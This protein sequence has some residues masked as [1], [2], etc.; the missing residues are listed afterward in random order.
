MSPVEGGGKQSCTND[1]RTSWLTRTFCESATKDS[2]WSWLT[3]A[4]G[5]MGYEKTTLGIHLQPALDRVSRAR[6]AVGPG[7]AG[8]RING[9]R[10]IGV[11]VVRGHRNRQRPHL[12]N[13]VVAENRHQGPRAS[14]VL[15]RRVPHVHGEHA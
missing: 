6:Q 5:A 12:V 9:R 4:F 8:V 1:S 2:R 10:L 7:V 15:R 11:D 14:G 3:K 13:R